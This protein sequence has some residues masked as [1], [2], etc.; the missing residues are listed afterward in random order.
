VTETT[1]AEVRA[2]LAALE[3]PKVR[4]VNQKH[5]VN[6]GQLRALANG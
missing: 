3:D 1:V 6:L 4:V 2:E 5:G